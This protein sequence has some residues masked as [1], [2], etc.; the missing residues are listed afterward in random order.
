ML[1]TYL[2]SATVFTT[3]TEES[4]E[5]LMYDYMGRVSAKIEYFF[6]SRLGSSFNQ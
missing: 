4:P 6:K 5:G 1:G 2:A 3:L